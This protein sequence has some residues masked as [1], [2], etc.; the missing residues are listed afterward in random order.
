M[1]HVVQKACTGAHLRDAAGRCRDAIQ[2]EVAERL[3]VPHKLTLTLQKCNSM[4][5]GEASKKNIHTLNNK[6]AWDR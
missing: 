4:C 3:V 5:S 2:A 6:T 1:S